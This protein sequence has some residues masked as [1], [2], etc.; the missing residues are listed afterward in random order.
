MPATTIL[1]CMGLFSIFL[2]GA[3]PAF[4]RSFPSVFAFASLKL[5]RTPRF[6]LWS[7]LGC[8][9]RSPKGEA[10]WAR[11]DSNLQ[12]DRYE[13]WKLAVFPLEVPIFIEF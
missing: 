10:W 9:T 12:P 4:A 7:P 2:S 5:R 8:A 3:R 13:R 11:Q 6:A 1:L